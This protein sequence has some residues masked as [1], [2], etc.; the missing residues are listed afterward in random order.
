MSDGGLRTFAFLFFASYNPSSTTLW[1]I[2]LY[3]YEDTHLKAMEGTTFK[4]FMQCFFSGLK[5]IIYVQ[6]CRAVSQ[7]VKLHL[8]FE[9]FKTRRNLSRNKK[10]WGAWAAQSVEEGTLDFCSGYDLRVTRSSPALDFELS[11]ESA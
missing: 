7:L 4:D 10:R 1:I 3:S 5:V 8:K 11:G 9:Q 6:V 2:S